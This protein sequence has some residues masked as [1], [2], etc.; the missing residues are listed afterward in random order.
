MSQRGVPVCGNRHRELNA[1][2]CVDAA[3][4]VGR[5]ALRQ[6]DPVSF[7]KRGSVVLP[8]CFDTKLCRV[9]FAVGIRADFETK[10]RIPAYS[11]DHER[12]FRIIV[13]SQVMCGVPRVSHLS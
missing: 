4:E 12:A 6:V 11:S 10:W 3:P 9:A 13:D 7:R 8:R 1:M 5:R 2:S